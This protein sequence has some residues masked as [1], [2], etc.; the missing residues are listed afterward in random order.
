MCL[1][2]LGMTEGLRQYQGRNDVLEPELGKRQPQLDVALLAASRTR[3]FA[4]AGTLQHPP[5]A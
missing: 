5:H 4:I 3:G 1:P 2:S